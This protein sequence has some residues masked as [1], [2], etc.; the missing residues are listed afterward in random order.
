MSGKIIA[1]LLFLIGFSVSTGVAAVNGYPPCAIYGMCTVDAIEAVRELQE[2]ADKLKA[3]IDAINEQKLET[4]GELKARLDRNTM[5][6]RRLADGI[7]LI[8][9]ISARGVSNETKI[10]EIGRAITDI[11]NSLSDDSDG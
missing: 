9:D 11:G 3:E 5:T 1:S 10:R 8:S 2:E 7:R 4:I 6:N